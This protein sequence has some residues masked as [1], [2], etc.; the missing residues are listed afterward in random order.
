[1][2]KKKSGHI[3]IPFLATL[4]IGLVIIGGA[5]MMLIKYLNREEPLKEA[6]AKDVETVSA[7]DDHTVL[8]IL[9]TPD[10]EC[11][12]TFMLMRSMPEDKEI[13]F[14]GIPANT[15]A[16]IDGKQHSLEGSF[17]E[18]GKGAK[19]AEFVE[20]VMG[21]PVERYMTFNSEAFRRVCDMTGCTKQY[22]VDIPFGGFK[23]DGSRENL[24]SEQMETYVTY[25]MFPN[26][27]ADRAFKAAA[28]MQYMVNGADAQA[29]ADHLEANFDQIINH[30]GISTNITRADYSRLKH[31]IKYLFECAAE[32][33]IQPAMAYKLNSGKDAGNDFIISD[34]Q[35]AELKKEY[36]SEA[37]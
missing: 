9:S 5:A 12:S 30:S 35:I 13:L 33:R 24:N 18:D 29:V 15:I 32:Y 16:V 4:F 11:K 28:L 14:V 37:E 3:A 19:A 36:F 21:V 34:V 1:M 10:K 6:P 22:P 8:L 20:A 25:S 27:E 2:S 17:K 23:G 31:A 7:E 26:G